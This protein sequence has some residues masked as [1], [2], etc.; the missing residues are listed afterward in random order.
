MN[1]IPGSR[2]SAE[3]VRNAGAA[4]GRPALPW[5]VDELFSRIDAMD[6][7]AVVG[8]FTDDV[9][10]RFA[11]QERVVGKPQVQQAVAAFFS[12]IG[13]LSHSI[14][15]VW[16]GSWEEGEAVGVES[17]VTYTRLDGARLAPLPAMT[18]LRLK[19]GLVKEFRV[20]VDLSPV[21]A[22]ESW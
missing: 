10:L 9:A 5:A 18:T 20:F 14:I 11:N 19:R 7:A 17:E 15:A 6:V 2:S 21:F 1:D 16:L 4:P 8:M 13:G 12:T 3:P 22:A